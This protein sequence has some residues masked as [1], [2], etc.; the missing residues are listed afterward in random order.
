[1]N[2]GCS[3]VK[4]NRILEPEDSLCSSGS[5]LMPK[6]ATHIFSSKGTSNNSQIRNLREPVSIT[7]DAIKNDF[8]IKLKNIRIRNLNRINLYPTSG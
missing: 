8:K 6:I 2:E 5:D 1:M 7:T 3:S 4:N